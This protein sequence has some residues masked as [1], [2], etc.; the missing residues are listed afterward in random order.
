MNNLNIRN[1]LTKFVKNTNGRI[2]KTAKNITEFAVAAAM[3]MTPVGAVHA[4]TSFKN[5][6]YPKERITH[7]IPVPSALSVNA[8]KQEVMEKQMTLADFVS[9]VYEA[10]NKFMNYI[11]YPD[12]LKDVNAAYYLVNYA[13]IT[14]ELEQELV[15]KGFIAAEDIVDSASNYVLT[16]EDQYNNVQRF[17][18]LADKINEYNTRVIREDYNNDTRDIEHL[19]NPSVLCYDKEHD[20]RDFDLLFKKYFE[21]Y[22]LNKGT[23][24]GN[25]SFDEAYKQLTELNAV[26]NVEELHDSSIGARW[27]MLRTTGIEMFEFVKDYLL[28]NYSIEELSTRFEEEGLRKE[29]PEF[30]QRTDYNI[31]RECLTELDYLSIVYGILDHHINDVG[32][33]DMFSV[34]IP[35]SLENGTN[36]PIVTKE[37]LQE[38][39]ENSNNY[40]VQ[41]EMSYD[42]YIEGVNK[43]YNYLSQYISYD[44][45]LDDIKSVIYL[46]NFEYISEDLENQLI[47]EGYITERDMVDA[48]GNFTKQNP[49]G[50]TNTDNFR[51]LMN[52]INEH[53][54]SK[55]HED[56]NHDTMDI[57]HYINPSI[58][59]F[60]QAKDGKYIN[61][62]FTKWYYEYNLEPGTIRN[63]QAYLDA[64]KMIRNIYDAG[65]S[66]GGEFLALF[67]SGNDVMQFE[68]DYLFKN[69][70]MTDLDEYYMPSE[71]RQYQLFLKEDANIDTN[72]ELG[73]VTDNFK[74][75]YDKCCDKISI[76][77]YQL[78]KNTELER[79]T[80]LY[81]N[82]LRKTM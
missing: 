55:I 52:T 69:Y 79:F 59:C 19:I 60:D 30:V 53:N 81:S 80:S 78:L 3:M 20:G 65:L 82:Q 12:I 57:S 63:N 67:S 4:D 68:R 75:H 56:Y 64:D 70:D 34:L 38:L 50:W 11:G 32:N 14:P 71:V 27:V 45:M 13:Y 66:I 44:H 6:T 31:N 35:M 26:E 15:A 76:K 48:E 73:F 9:G 23:F 40:E 17:F 51:S 33:H 21:G 49:N 58:F 47:N 25:Y 24:V 28:A 29:I 41:S 42:Q 74:A 77:L 43:A 37:I 39:E 8:Q 2:S 54:Q 72:T 22:N 46:A 18:A 5:F 36:S 7:E 1:N 62:L 10:S 61:E 16:E